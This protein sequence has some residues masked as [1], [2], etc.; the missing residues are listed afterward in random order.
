MHEYEY[1]WFI[2]IMYEYEWFITIMCECEWFITIMCEWF[3]TIMYEWFITIVS[4]AHRKSVHLAGKFPV[5]KPHP[6][7]GGGESGDGDHQ[8]VPQ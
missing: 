1:E 7:N 4:H 3:I 5:G 8:P 2:T 6:E